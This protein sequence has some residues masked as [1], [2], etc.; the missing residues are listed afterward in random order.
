[1]NII[2]T[3]ASFT[4]TDPLI[5]LQALIIYIYVYVYTYVLLKVLNLFITLIL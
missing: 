3:N 4:I 1:M 2:K 5:A